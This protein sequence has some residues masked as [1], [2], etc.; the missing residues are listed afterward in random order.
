LDRLALEVQMSSWCRLVRRGALALVLAFGLQ[1]A[2]AAL[3]NAATTNLGEVGFGSIVVDNAQHH[4]FVSEPAGNAVAELNLAGHL[5]RTVRH[6][7]GAAGM[8]LM[9]KN[10]YVAESTAGSIV[11]IARGAVGRG[12][13]PV[14]TGLNGPVW[15]SAAG[16]RIWAALHGASDGWDRVVGINPTSGAKRALSGTFYDPDLASSRGDPTSLY[17]AQDGLSPGAITRFDVGGARPVKKA[18]NGSTDQENIEGLV[19]SADGSRV[20]PA[21]GAP[22]TFE[23][24]CTSTLRADGLRYPAEPYPSADA[25]SGSGSL[26]TGITNGDTSPDLAVYRLG[27]PQSYF[28]AST[29]GSLNVAPHGLALTKNASEL[30]AISDDSS[31][32]TLLNTYALPSA[33]AEPRTNPCRGG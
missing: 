14:V 1:A 19:I 23:E 9:G 11:R 27:A 24:M 3:T 4:V 7:Y 5:L 16:G 22:Y 6:V 31:G 15:L 32:D 2:T 10:L 29:A 33:P 20:I 13:H 28:E 12:A 17:V 30:F 26:A 8:A 18:S 25:V 21:S